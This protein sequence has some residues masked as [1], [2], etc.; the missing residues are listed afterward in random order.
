LNSPLVGDLG[1]GDSLA[2][3]V[4]AALVSEENDD[5]KK[6]DAL[7]SAHSEESLDCLSSYF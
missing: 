2:A 3:I 5:F 4:N 1:Q 6:V 7:L